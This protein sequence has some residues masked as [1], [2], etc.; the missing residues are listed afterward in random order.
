LRFQIGDLLLV[1]ADMV[2]DGRFERGAART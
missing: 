1:L 2:G